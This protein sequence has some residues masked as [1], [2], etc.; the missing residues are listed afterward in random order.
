MGSRY[1]RPG[2]AEPPQTALCGRT[3]TPRPDPLL[4]P[5]MLCCSSYPRAQ[6]GAG[7]SRGWP[8]TRDSRWLEP[9][10]KLHTCSPSM[11]GLGLWAMMP[12]RCSRAEVRGG[13]GGCATQS[14]RA[15][16]AQAACGWWEG[17]GKVALDSGRGRRREGQ[18]PREKRHASLPKPAV[19]LPPM[20]SIF[21]LRWCS[22]VLSLSLLLS[23]S[24]ALEVLLFK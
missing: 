21:C 23:L 24:N 8:A 2:K 16:G 7:T 17:Q 13:V 10:L 11:T 1:H 19:H 3:H 5:S 18:G 12:T 22:I 20:L 4:L 14:S 9:L 15:G 6:A